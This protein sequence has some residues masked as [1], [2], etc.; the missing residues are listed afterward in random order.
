MPFIC[1]SI[2]LCLELLLR[3]N[4]QTIRTQ[5][6]CMLLKLCTYTSFNHQK[7]IMGIFPI[8]VLYSQVTET[9]HMSVYC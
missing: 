6:G 8:T 9:A 3:S 7:A 2:L 1:V 4:A 5:L